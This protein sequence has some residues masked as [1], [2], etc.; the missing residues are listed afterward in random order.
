MAASG[1]TKSK[2]GKMV[3][4]SFLRGNQGVSQISRFSR[5]KGIKGTLIRGGEAARRTLE[6]SDR[7]SRRIRSLNARI[8]KTSREAQ[9][10]HRPIG[11]KAPGFRVKR[12]GVDPLTV[13]PRS[14]VL[15]NASFRRA[16][17]IGGIQ[18]DRAFRGSSNIQKANRMTGKKIKFP[19]TLRKAVNRGISRKRGAGR[20]KRL[21]NPRRR[22]A[23]TITRTRFFRNRRSAENDD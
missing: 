21:V 10:R 18:S 8:R 19:S 5:D 16:Q 20:N 11:A 17:P 2:S 13:G 14:R 7:S 15:S 23:N 22:K 6:R 1:Y 3:K 4:R 12:K 9:V